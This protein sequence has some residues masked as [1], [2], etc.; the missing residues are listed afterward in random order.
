[1]SRATR[2][3]SRVCCIGAWLNYSRMC[4]IA[5]GLGLGT[6]DQAE[7]IEFSAEVHDAQ[8]A[9]YASCLSPKR[10]AGYLG[11]R[12][13][14]LNRLVSVGLIGLRFDL[15]RL[16]PIYH[17]D[18]LKLLVEPLVGQAA[19][20][21][22]LP[23]GY[24]SLISIGGHAKCRFETVMRLACDGKLATLSRLDA[25]PKLD[26]LFVSLDD[27]RDQLEVPAP[28]GITRVEAKRL[29]RINSSTVAWLIR[30]GWL[31]AK[32]VKHHRY[33]R[34]VTL[35]SREALEEFL[36]SYAT[37]G[38]MAADGHTQA[39]HVAR[40]LEKVG[41][42]PLDL[43]CRLSKLYPRTPQPERL[44]DPGRMPEPTPS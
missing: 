16:N 37:L 1:M 17:P 43:D 15:P 32:T 42:F 9:N 23:S 14:M 30:Q 3:Q 6:T 13:E 31:P 25:I 26:G 28:S 18:D 34:P 40:K 8:I 11:I 33:R 38:M 24:A 7:C 2:T 36:N 10:S 29:L 19:F 22:H 44:F 4:R 39:M 21:D 35:I 41:I 20:M 12:G 27:L 5:V